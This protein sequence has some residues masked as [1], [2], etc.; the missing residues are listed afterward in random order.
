MELLR[1]KKLQDAMKGKANYAIVSVGPNFYYLTGYLPLESPDRAFFLVVPDE[2]EPFVLA[3]ELY[4]FE[5]EKLELEKVFYKDGEDPYQKL[6]SLIKG[7]VILLDDGMS[8]RQVLRVQTSV[9][10]KA[11]GLLST[12]INELRV[13]KDDSELELITKA[14]KIADR[15][16][17]KVASEVYP[18]LREDEL[19][20][21]INEYL[22]YYGAEGLAFKTIVASGPNSAEPHHTVS[23]RKIK[24]GDVVI[25]DF[26]ARYK[27]YV[28]DITRTLL[29][30]N[31][32]LKF[33]E[34]YETVK[35][36][37]AAAAKTVKPGVSA[38][39]VDSAARE[40]ISSKGYGENF[41]HRTGH[42]IGLEVHEEPF[43]DPSNKLKL[44]DGMTFTIEPGI[45][46]KG[47]YGVRIE[48]DYVLK[49]KAVR[50]TSS[51]RNLLT[52]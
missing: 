52:I 18:G 44:K 21:I 32:D 19:A 4:S 23:D 8:F 45:Y 3:P 29:V 40:V 42:G 41:I 49:E 1:I 10:A 12:V 43:L 14:A 11:Y 36:A 39:E 38:S 48:D 5:L 28:S 47:K 33:I 15:S 17:E 16:F 50:L 37:Q 31:A 6:S 13:E 9:E 27:G 34:I 20:E 22:A 26:G 51:T 46:I 7:G 25:L 2:G 35:K 30:G 24:K